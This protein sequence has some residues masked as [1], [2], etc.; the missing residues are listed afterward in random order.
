MLCFKHRLKGFIFF[1]AEVWLNFYQ[2]SVLFLERKAV[3]HS[4]LWCNRGYFLLHE[5]CLNCILH[6]RSAVY[7]QSH[8]SVTYFCFAISAGC[9][10]PKQ[11]NKRAGCLLMLHR[12][13]SLLNRIF[14][15][16]EI[17][18]SVIRPPE[19]D[20]GKHL[21]REGCSCWQGRLMFS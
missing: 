8:C 2:L 19:V 11:L 14:Q 4:K 9:A 7:V 16:R 3:S 10:E 12:E 15:Y 1:N 6:S 21:G 13:I 20:N 5:D 18:A 17:T